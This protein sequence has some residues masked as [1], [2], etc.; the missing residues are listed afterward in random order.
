MILVG[1]FDMKLSVKWKI[2]LVVFTFIHSTVFADQVWVDKDVNFGQWQRIIIMDLMGSKVQSAEPVDTV[3]IDETG[4]IISNTEKLSAEVP[5]A[6]EVSTKDQSINST[7][8]KE[9]SQVS[10]FQAEM[11]KANPAEVRA[12]S[13]EPKS[14]NRRPSYDEMLGIAQAEWIKQGERKLGKRGVVLIPFSTSLVEL[15]KRAPETDWQA[16]WNSGDTAEFW[17]LASPYLENYADGILMGTMNTLGTGSQYVP[18]TTRSV[19]VQSGGRFTK[20]GGYT[21]YYTTQYY[22]TEGYDATTWEA[23]G[24]FQL[25]DM[26]GTL[27]WEYQ[28]PSSKVIGGWFSNKSAESF[29][30]GYFSNMMGEV[31]IGKK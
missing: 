15:A 3:Q 30:E 7:S 28:K 6:S 25:L 14:S 19:Q 23:S 21:P 16:L 11:A 27:R 24:T 2:L 26:T 18:P 9:S 22:K 31:P 5:A 4:K 10:I 29:L 17:K 12:S 20:G 13:V 1:G 8:E